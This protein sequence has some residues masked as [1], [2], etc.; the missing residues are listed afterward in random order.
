MWAIDS[1]QSVFD[2]RSY[3]QRILDSIWQVRLS[4]MLLTVFGAVALTLAAIGIYGVMSF[5]VGQRKREIG[6]RLALGAT[7]VAVRRLVVQHGL[8]VGLAG[9]ALGLLAALALGRMIEH[10][11]SRVTAADP[12]IFILPVA[13][14]LAVSV[15]ACAAPAWRA[16]RLD[17]AITLRQE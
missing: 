17:P 15:L 4:R 3:D 16:S 2:F 12:M 1:E 10:A 11:L 8:I 13:A 6:I 5:L 14:L 9:T 7:P